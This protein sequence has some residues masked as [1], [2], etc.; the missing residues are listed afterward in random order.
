MTGTTVE[1]WDTMLYLKDTSSPQ[2]YDQAIFRLQ[3]QYIKELV[4]EVGDV[5]KFNMKPQTLLV[6]FS[7]NRVFIMQEQKAQIYNVNTDANGNNKLEERLKRELEISPIIT[8]NSNKIIQIEATDV[9]D[10][11][12]KYSSERS[13][14][15]E[16]IDIPIDFSLLD[17]DLIKD[18]IQ[19]QGEIGSKQGLKIENTDSE[20]GDDLDIPDSE[21]E[22]STES[23]NSSSKNNEELNE[24]SLRKKF[25]T[26][27]SKILFFSFLT[28]SKIKSLKDI[29]DLSVEEEN[30]RIL[31]NLGLNIK[32]LSLLNDNINPFILKELDYKIHNINS[33]ANDERLSEFDRATIALNKFSRLSDSEVVTPRNVAKSLIE[34]I[35]EASVNTAFKILDIASKQGEFVYATFEKF[36]KNVANNFYSIPTSNIAYEFTRKVYTLLGLD[37]NKIEKNY[38]SYDLLNKDDIVINNEIKI[39][40]TAM[41]FDAIVGNPPYQ[42]LDGGAQASAKPI[43][44]EFVLLAKKI[45]PKYYSLI[46]PARWYAG[47]RG[48]DDFRDQMINDKSIFE[49]HDFLNP[50]DLFPNTNIRGGICMFISDRDYNN[51]IDLV[52]VTTYKKDKSTSAKRLLKSEYSNTF[53][54]FNEALSIIEKVKYEN[55]IDKYV[56][57]L[58]PFG[59]RGYF[60][61]D[62]KFRSSSENLI[63]PV[64]CYGKGK[65]MGFLEREEIEVRT[66]WIDKFK[67]FTPR[68]N[69]IATEL[70][71][72]N[73]NSFIGK[74][75]TICTESYIVIG[76][77][78]DFNE[79]E[80]H[81]LSIY[82]KTK[83]VRFLHSL[84]KSSQDATSKTY[85][86]VPIQDFTE[87][88][89]IDWTKDVSNIDLQLYE[90]YKLSKEEIQF[91]EE[92][93]KPM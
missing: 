68:A 81:N 5:I 82:L 90:K 66:N 20:N 7:P 15:D 63:N 45:N 17:I 69:N 64:I 49:L 21:T 71:D 18:V 34:L 83:F 60:I 52:K 27:Y 38:S 28:D 39:N 2:E 92:S 3:N 76:A 36:G 77:D 41:K 86:F 54:R 46:I 62:E 12:R 37:I 79:I 89:D 87:K 57:A 32:I 78:L 4:N 29:V 19:K 40:N 85:K 8:I 26:Y 67:V 72:D 25:A 22:S 65:K 44:Q 53:I 88:S 42:M 93:I 23:S 33:L 43:Y 47:G 31:N 35:P 58:R 55:K 10:A 13:V 70:N 74:P 30:T 48:L 56:S 51:E 61:N 11:V 75:G 24:N 16:A 73:L 14:L 50:E 9:L 80:S 91:I 59:F 1:E 6:D 84:A